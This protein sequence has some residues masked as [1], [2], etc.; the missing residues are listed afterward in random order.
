MVFR[1]VNSLHKSKIAPIEIEQNL[2]LKDEREGQPCDI[3]LIAFS[4]ILAYSKSIY[5][6]SKLENLGPALNHS[7]N[8]GIKSLSKFKSLNFNKDL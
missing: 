1:L 2:N 3:A 8:S 7:K 4:G 6:S 5:N